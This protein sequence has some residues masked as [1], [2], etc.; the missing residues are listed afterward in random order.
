MLG[1]SGEGEGMDA[2]LEIFTLGG[3]QVLLG[4][5]PVAGL[6]TRKAEALLIYLASTRRPQPREVLADLLWD[7]RTQS[8]AMGNLRG[9]LTNLR[10]ALGDSLTIT[11]EVA[12]INPDAVIWLDSLELENNLSAIRKQGK[13]KPDTARQ[14][15]SILELYKGEFLEGFTVFDCR[16]FE[17]WSVRERE[18]M[19]HLAV[20]G[21]SELVTF[22]IEGQ[23]YQLGMAT[24]SP[25]AG[26]GPPE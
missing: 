18:R 1:G 7:E 22:D 4:G 21:L 16:G 14:A 12:G 20:D 3:V 2:K 8:Q 13:L 9:V 10:Q 26:V 19:H 15:S 25:S 24:C 23:E 6:G 5:E 17:E 11:R